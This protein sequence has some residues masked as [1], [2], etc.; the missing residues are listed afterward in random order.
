MGKKSGTQQTSNAPWDAAQPSLKFGLS[1]L[2]RIYSGG[3][4]T[5]EQFTR[6]VAPTPFRQGMSGYQGFTLQNPFGN[7]NQYQNQTTFDQAGYDQAMSAFQ[8]QTPFSVND[9]GMIDPAMQEIA[10]TVRGDRFNQNPYMDD[11]IARSMQ[12]VNSQFQRSGRYGSGAHMDQLF[13]EAAAPIRYANYDAERQRQLAAAQMAPMLPYQ[14]HSAQQAAPYE[15]IR[16]YLDLVNP[17]AGQGGQASQPIYKNQGAGVLG[18]AMSGAALGSMMAA[19][20]ATGLA[21]V[22]GW[23]F[24]LGGALLGGL[25][26]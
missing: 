1:E 19:P 2:N 18:G 21:A 8:A 16:N 4:P 10:A 22:G 13:T 15:G 24:L 9:Y 20:G 12:D 5:R 7:Q 25:M 3:A 11:V 17:I 26:Q 14:L 6:N 23:P